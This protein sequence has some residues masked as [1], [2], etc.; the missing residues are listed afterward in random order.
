MK[1]LKTYKLFE[2]IDG[3]DYAIK[4]IDLFKTNPEILDVRIAGNV[5][6]IDGWVEGYVKYLSLEDNE[7]S[8]VYDI[9]VDDSGV[10]SEES[11]P[12]S[13]LTDEDAKNLYEY[14]IDKI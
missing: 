4:L 7:L 2:D 5:S 9:D 14:I 13:L 3:V 12:V 8:V 10:P 1:Y 11:M 6:I